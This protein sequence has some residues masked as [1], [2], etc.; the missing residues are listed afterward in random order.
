MELR[1]Y[2]FG[3]DRADVIRFR[4]VV[5]NIV[6]GESGPDLWLC[7]L[8]T[9][10]PPLTCRIPQPRISSTR[11][12]MTYASRDGQKP[13]AKALLAT[14]T[15]ICVPPLSWSTLCKPQMYPIPC[16]IGEYHCDWQLRSLALRCPMFLVLISLHCSH[17]AFN[18]KAHLSEMEQACFRSFHFACHYCHVIRSFELI[19]KLFSLPPL[20]NATDDYSW[21]CTLRIAKA[22]WELIRQRFGMPV[23]LDSSTTMW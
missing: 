11:S 10:I 16:N 20:S 17:V 8:H 12:S 18:L 3:N 6:L 15:I 7:D 22:A 4:Q 9:P 1:A 21:N 19:L 23:R 14:T 13:L 5:V 2:L